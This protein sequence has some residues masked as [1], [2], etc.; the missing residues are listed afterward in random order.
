MGFPAVVVRASQGHRAGAA[1]GRP[2]PNRAFFTTSGSEAVESAW[3]LA[4]QYFKLIARRTVQKAISRDI[5]YHGGGHGR[6]G[7][8][9]PGRHQVPVRAADTGRCPG[10]EH[11]LLP[12]AAFVHDGHR[13]RSVPGPG[14]D[15][16][17]HPPRGTQVGRG[18]LTWSP[19]RIP[20]GASRRLPVT[21][22]GSGRSATGTA[23][24]TRR[25]A[26]SRL[27]FGYYFGSERYGYPAGHH[28]LRQG[29]HLRLCRAPP[30]RDGSVSDALIQP[31][32]SRTA[33]FT[34]SRSPITASPARSRWPTWTSSRRKT[35]WETSGEPKFRATFEKLS[36]LPKIVG[37]VRGAG[38]YLLRAGQGQHHYREMFDDDES[39]RLLRGFLSQA[40]F[41]GGLCAAP[42]TVAR[43]PASSGPAADL[44]PGAYFDEME[45]ILR[46]VLTEAGHGFRAAG[47]GASPSGNRV[48]RNVLPRH[49]AS[50]SGV[51][52]AALRFRYACQLRPRMTIA[53]PG[54][55]P[56]ASPRVATVLPAIHLTWGEN[57]ATS[58]VVAQARHPGPVGG[59]R[60]VVVAEVA[61]HLGL[62]GG[63]PAPGRP[64]E[65]TTLVAG[66][67]PQVRWICSGVPLPPAAST[68]RRDTGDRDGR[69]SPELA[70]IT[71]R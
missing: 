64:Q 53:V 38:N 71:E 10:A 20:A 17:G 26:R 40:L 8:H 9:R 6:A 5:A 12:G 46:A 4:K 36:D 49:S 69:A 63:S 13:R 66:F 18:G 41:D 23:C 67:S 2:G 68:C 59:R 37:E 14:R 31:F 44:R 35:C 58:V 51:Y 7:H 70:G 48:H 16:T 22:S 24:C 33:T 61:P 60:P 32:T 27:V 50:P 56:G 39:E 11:Q 19:C 54:V 42:M 30:G 57:P 52:S 3:K 21:S 15:R 29:G 34:A 25:S 43:D 47:P 45:A 55:T 1:A 65:T 62:D 28:H